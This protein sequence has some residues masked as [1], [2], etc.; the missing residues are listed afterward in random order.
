VCNRS[1]E[2]TFWS[3]AKVFCYY[4]LATHL[5][6]YDFFDFTD[7]QKQFDFLANHIEQLRNRACHRISEVTI[8]V[9]RNLGF[10][11]EHHKRALS[12]IPLVKF[13]IDQKANRVGVYTSEDVK[14]AMCQLVN[15]MLA[16]RRIHLLNPL[17]S[18]NPPLVREKLREQLKTYSYQV[19]LAQNTFQKDRIALSGKVGGCKDDICIC[20][21]LACYFSH[22]ESQRAAER[23]SNSNR[24][25]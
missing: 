6:T 20:L 22:I 13:Y 2:S 14:H 16:E 19:K 8:F 12:D 3:D 11:A 10:E 5:Q 1:L 9:E 21:Q 4:L 15:V 18:T 7:P 24:V 25:D 23:V 17:I